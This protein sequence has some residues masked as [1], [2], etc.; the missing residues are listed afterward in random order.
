MGNK[1]LTLNPLYGLVRC[2]PSSSKV[3]QVKCCGLTVK[4]LFI[5]VCM[6]D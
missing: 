5:V 1:S 3:T 6:S 2:E 4:A